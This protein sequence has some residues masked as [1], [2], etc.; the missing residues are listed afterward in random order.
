MR[1]SLAGRLGRVISPCKVEPVRY[2]SPGMRDVVGVVGLL[3]MGVLTG[4]GAGTSYVKSPDTQLGR[5]VV[6]RNG[7]AYFER[8][9][10]IEGDTLH[11]TVPGDKVDDF[12]KSLTVIDAHTNQPAPIAYPASTHTG[13]GELIDMQIKLQGPGPHDLRLTYVT[14]AP[15][16]KPSYRVVLG[17]N[18]KVN[19]QGW[20]IVDNTSGEDWHGVKLGVGAS[21]ALSFRFDLW[22]V[23]MVQRETLRSDDLFAQAPPTGGATHGGRANEQRVLGDLSEMAVAAV[24]QPAPPPAE[25]AV[26]SRATRKPTAQQAPKAA[27]RGK[28]DEDGR[29]MGGVAGGFG[30]GAAAPSTGAPRRELDALAQRINSSRNQVIIEGY[31][32]RGDGDKQAASLDRANKVRDQLLRQGVSPD[33]VV[34]VG[35]GEQTGKQGGVRLIEGPPAEEKKNGD[36]GK[37]ADRPGGN[38]TPV[39]AA[40]DPSSEP[41]GTSHFESTSAMDVARGSA[42]MVSV[43]QSDTDG[44]VVYLFDRESPRG[45]ASFPFRAVRLRNPTDSALESGPV[46]VFGDGRFI[47]E[48]MSEPIPARASSFIPFALDRQ[49]VVEQKGED[50][51]DISRILAVQRGVFS[52]EVQHTRRSTLTL[53]NRL[54][55]P[56]T[57]YIRHTI[58]AGYHLVKGPPVAE[59]MGEASLFRV[60]VPAGGSSEV[61]LEEATPVTRTVDMR[62]AEGMGL[63]KVFLSSATLT[64]PLRQ[65]VSELIKLQQEMG[66]IEQQIASAREQMGEFKQRMDELHAQLVTLRAVKNPQ[67]N[68]MQ[69]LE[70]KLQEVS[71]K[72]SKSTLDLVALQEKLMVARIRFQDGLADLSLERKSEPP[73]PPDPATSRG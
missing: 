39:N 58:P 44:E 51:D 35:R 30:A 64:G 52:T 36:E 72:M 37:P 1:L 34:A 38:A 17:Q 70:K 55:E 23:R 47:G 7:V 16:W 21:S 65:S 5:V 73:T 31:A 29:M 60:T 2:V 57:V 3:A 6:Y 71:E 24:T 66:T 40:V 42:A 67:G 43:M 25:V 28:D 69:H 22:S 9:A 26:A 53:T 45:N 61:V 14:E 12:L 46:T 15:A 33:R 48:G 11:L 13:G 32:E 62:S 20:A 10:R 63:I 41:I 50:R 8:T 4:C 49:I 27:R 68:L 19:L 59:K 56:A 18:G 54:T